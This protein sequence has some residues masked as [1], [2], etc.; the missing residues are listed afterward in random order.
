[1]RPRDRK[2]EQ[3]KQVIAL[4]ESGDGVSGGRAL[5]DM[6]MVGVLASVYGWEDPILGLLEAISLEAEVLAAAAEANVNAPSPESLSSLLLMI[7]RKAE[8]AMELYKRLESA[9]PKD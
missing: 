8:V 1:M 4:I 6:S 2:V 3:G 7:R 9:R 5:A